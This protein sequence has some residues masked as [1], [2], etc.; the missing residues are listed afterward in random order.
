MTLREPIMWAE[1]VP[2][3]VY[4]E[5]VGQRE[6]RIYISDDEPDL[7]W[8]GIDN[9]G[10]YV[11]ESSQGRRAEMFDLELLLWSD[12]TTERGLEFTCSGC[13]STTIGLYGPS[14]FDIAKRTQSD[15]SGGPAPI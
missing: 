4:A 3:R 10:E 14:G 9:E 6:S 11:L 1:S 7:T 8:L 5:Q 12:T 2:V 13:G 15:V